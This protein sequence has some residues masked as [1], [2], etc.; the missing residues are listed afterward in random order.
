MKLER[1][2]EIAYE[3]FNRTIVELIPKESGLLVQ[4][5][6]WSPDL[7]GLIVLL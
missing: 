2:G 1:V 5:N 4:E 3:C 7:S 6:V